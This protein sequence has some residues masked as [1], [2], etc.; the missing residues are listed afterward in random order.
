MQNIDTSSYKEEVSYLLLT[1]KHVENVRRKES[2]NLTKVVVRQEQNRTDIQ[3]SVRTDNR[4]EVQ[5]GLLVEEVSLLSTA[6]RSRVRLARD[7]VTSRSPQ[8]DLII[9]SQHLNVCCDFLHGS[10]PEAAHCWHHW[11]QY[12]GWLE[13]GVVSCAVTTID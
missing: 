5:A 12:T 2:W 10:R 3:E 6:T 4:L 7:F 1:S 13:P 8:L 11:K 9:A